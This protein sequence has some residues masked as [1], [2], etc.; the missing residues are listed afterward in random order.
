MSSE[1][2]T[3]RPHRF[4]EANQFIT[5]Q[6]RAFTSS[7]P[8]SCSI[9]RSPN[10][11]GCRVLASPPRLKG[12]KKSRSKSNV[13]S[14]PWPWLRILVKGREDW[15]QAQQRREGLWGDGRGEALTGRGMDCQ[16]EINNERNAGSR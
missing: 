9:G 7:L 14:E 1:C 8:S 10:E 4:C 6:R 16:E 13:E 12:A 11:R 2:H 15:C 3:L 5:S